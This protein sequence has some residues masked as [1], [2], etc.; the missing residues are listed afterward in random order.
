MPHYN[1]KD[2]IPDVPHKVVDDNAD[3]EGVLLAPILLT[4]KSIKKN[5]YLKKI[6][7]HFGP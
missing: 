4:I 1:E 2:N 3:Q 7:I 6:Y 5:Q